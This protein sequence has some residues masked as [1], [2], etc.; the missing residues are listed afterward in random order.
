MEAIRIKGGG[1]SVRY[2]LAHKLARV[3]SRADRIDHADVAVGL[4]FLICYH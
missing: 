3:I 2:R 4:P 1:V